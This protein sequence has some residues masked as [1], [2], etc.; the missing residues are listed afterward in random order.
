[1]KYQVE[2]AQFVTLEVE[3][4]SKS[5]AEDQAAVMEDDEIE[6]KGNNDRGWVIW[7]VTDRY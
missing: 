7:Q 5:E 6:S 2:F 4:D 1:M 3:A